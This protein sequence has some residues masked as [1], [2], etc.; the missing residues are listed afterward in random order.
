MLVSPDLLALKSESEITAR[1]I[2]SLALHVPLFAERIEVIRQRF[3]VVSWAGALQIEQVDDSRPHRAISNKCVLIQLARRQSLSTEGKVPQIKMVYDQELYDKFLSPV[4]RS[5]LVLHEYL[6]L[7]ARETGHVDSDVIR[8]FNAFLFA[9]DHPVNERTN[10]AMA[11]IMRQ[12]VGRPFGDYMRFFLAEADL[13]PTETSPGT[14]ESRYHSLISLMTKMRAD[15]ALCRR[16]GR[17]QIE[18]QQKT[19]EGD[20]AFKNTLTTEEAFLFIGRFYLD[21]EMTK[22]N[23]EM[24]SARSLKISATEPS[25]LNSQIS[26]YCSFMQE[27]P[28]LQYFLIQDL[29]LAYC[30]DQLAQPVSPFS[31]RPLEHKSNCVMKDGELPIFSVR[32]DIGLLSSVFGL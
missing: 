1:I 24:L 12:F 15:M 22:H 5:M 28:S 32:S 7:I 17:T 29:A 21:G 6:Y 20:S 27:K 18:C 16:E 3:P 4:E 13:K 30:R 23:S 11:G 10:P 2:Q 26:D 19:V 25:A 9:L 14:Q 31:S 8:P